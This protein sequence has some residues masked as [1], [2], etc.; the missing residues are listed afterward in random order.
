MRNRDKRTAERFGVLDKVENL[1][2]DLLTIPGV[3]EVEYDLDGFYDDMRQ[4]IVLTKYCVPMNDYDYFQKRSD[5][6]H[7]VVAI[8]ARHGLSRTGDGIEDYG[9]HFY[10][11]F[12][13]DWQTREGETV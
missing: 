10:F 12:S 8:A 2:R 13:C 3:V 5:I 11:V 9:E 6:L 7:N 1:E 4:V